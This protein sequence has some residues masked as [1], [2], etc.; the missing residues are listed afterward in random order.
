MKLRLLKDIVIPAGT[1]FDSY[2][3]PETISFGSDNVEHVIGFGRNASG[4]LYIG[5]E[6][7]DA[8]FQEWFEPIERKKKQK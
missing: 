4:T 3:V 1:V 7:H 8:E 5:A 2:G 6:P